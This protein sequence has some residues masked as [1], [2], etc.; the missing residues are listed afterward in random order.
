MKKI[1]VVLFLS[2]F[3]SSV[4]AQVKFE[5][6][7]ERSS[8]GLNERIQLVFSINNEGDNF[9]PPKFLVLKPKGHSLTKETKLL[10]R[11]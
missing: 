1:F 3:C 4:F 11:L 2:F 10:L 8:Y 5:A 6:Q 7:T 9:V